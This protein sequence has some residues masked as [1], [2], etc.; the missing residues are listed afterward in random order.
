MLNPEYAERAHVT[1][2]YIAFINE[3]LGANSK[4]VAHRV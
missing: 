3:L 1:K 4:R 2:G